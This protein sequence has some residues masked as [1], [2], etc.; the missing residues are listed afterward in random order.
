MTDKE[1]K[2]LERCK[3]LIKENHSCWIGL[4]NQDAINTMLQLVEKQDSK[5]KEKREECKKCIVRD[6]LHYYI[7]EVE[8]KDKIIDKMAEEIF[9]KRALA[10]TSEQDIDRLKQKIIGEY[11]NK[12]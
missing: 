7:E 5:I 1:I 11:K 9:I 3:E 8:K 10:I 2:A 12:V 6:N 4:S